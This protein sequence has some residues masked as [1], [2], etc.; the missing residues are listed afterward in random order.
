M[1]YSYIQQAIAQ[2]EAAAT[3]LKNMV[4][5]VPPEQAKILQVREVEE[6]I[7]NTLAHIE[8]AINPPS[9]E[10]LP[11]DV[12]ERAQALKIPLGDVEVQMAMVSHDL[13]QVMAILT[14]MENRAQTIRRRREYFLV[15]LPDMPIEVLGSRLPVYTAADF[16]APP[17]PVSKEVRDQLKAKYG[18]D[19]LIMEKSVRSRATLF[20]QIKQAKQTL[21]HP[22]PQDE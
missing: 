12:L 16:Q 15:R 22:S 14:E 11:P 9:L 19:R 8:A 1:D 10:H 6:K 2:L 5:H 18:I 21:E 20:D 3:E 13:S 4:D 7:R 17:E